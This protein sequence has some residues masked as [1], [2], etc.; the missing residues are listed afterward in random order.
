MSVS[1][2]RRCHNFRLAF[3]SRLTYSQPVSRVVPPIVSKG[4]RYSV[5]RLSE[6]RGKRYCQ[7]VWIAFVGTR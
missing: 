2:A 6:D 4:V 1:H 7:K 5:L 3:V